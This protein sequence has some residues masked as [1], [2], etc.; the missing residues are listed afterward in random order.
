VLI[1]Y[2]GCR[3]GMATAA[4]M[5]WARLS[6]DVSIFDSQLVHHAKLSWDST[7]IAELS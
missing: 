6:G 1:R 7:P 2:V 3:Q 5:A 4:S